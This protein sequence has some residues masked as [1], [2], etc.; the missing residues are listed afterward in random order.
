MPF[1][2]GNTGFPENQRRAKLFAEALRMEI[3]AAGDDHQA[4]RRVARGLLAEACNGNVAAASMIADRLDGKV[5]QPTGGS[6]ELS[7]GCTLAGAARPSPT[8]RWRQ[9]LRTSSRSTNAIQECAAPGRNKPVPRKR[10]TQRSH[11]RA[12]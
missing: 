10:P 9:Q 2:R 5:P 12:Y 11:E 7:S 6:E 1:T 4:L 8:A 3:A